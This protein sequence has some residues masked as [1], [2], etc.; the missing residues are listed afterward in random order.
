MNISGVFITNLNI[1]VYYTLFEC[2][3]AMVSNVFIS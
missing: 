2:F 1:H 3:E